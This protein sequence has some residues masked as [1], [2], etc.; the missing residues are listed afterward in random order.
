MAIIEK[1]KNASSNSSD[2]PA[3]TLEE[4]NLLTSQSPKEK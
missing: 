1:N 4:L 3:M 2:H